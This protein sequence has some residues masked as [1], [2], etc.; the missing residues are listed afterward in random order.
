MTVLVDSHLFNALLSKKQ[1]TEI[2]LLILEDI[3]IISSESIVNQ[4]RDYHCDEETSWYI[5]ATPIIIIH[6]VS[7]EL[8]CKFTEND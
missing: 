5:K 8:L 7:V 6:S 4:C 3:T 2:K 1:F